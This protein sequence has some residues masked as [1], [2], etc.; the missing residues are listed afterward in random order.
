MS[1]AEKMEREGIRTSSRYFLGK[2]I[3]SKKMLTNALGEKKRP[4]QY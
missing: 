1:V 3:I 4:G 2:I